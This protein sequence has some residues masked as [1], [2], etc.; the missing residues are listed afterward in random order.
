[1]TANNDDGSVYSCIF[2]SKLGAVLADEEE[3]VLTI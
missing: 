2:E 3:G 1:M